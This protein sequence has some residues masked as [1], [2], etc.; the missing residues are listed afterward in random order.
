MKSFIIALV[1]LV[2]FMLWFRDWASTGKMDAFIEAHEDP[3]STPGLLF[4]M[5]E[6]CNTAN[7][8]E[9]ASRYYKWL[10]DKYPEKKFMP[11]VRFHLAQNYEEMGKRREAMEQYIILK[12]SFTLTDYG[13]MAEKKWETTRF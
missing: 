11:R 9:N 7:S 1:C 5:A 8:P 12:D 3:D 13:R 4:V 10:V 6:A 2:A